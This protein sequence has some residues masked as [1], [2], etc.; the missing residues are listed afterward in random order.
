MAKRRSK[1]R[2]EPTPPA[3]PPPAPSGSPKWLLPAVAATVAVSAIA[4]YF[5]AAE[6]V[7]AP[8]TEPAQ[9]QLLIAGSPDYVDG[10]ACAGCHQEIA[11]TYAETGMGRSFYR[12]TPDT[13]A[14]LG[15][16]RS[17]THQRSGRN[18]EVREEG[19]R[20]FLRREEI[21]GGNVF[22]REIHYVMGS[23]AHARSYLHQYADGRAV[24]LPLG[25][26]SDGGGK[27]AMSPG[28]DQP[29]H[30]GFG[31]EIGFE[32]MACH[33]GYPR[34]EPGTDAAGLDPRF[35][36]R[37]VEGIDCQ[38]CHGPGKAHI[39][40]VAADQPEEVVRAA[41]FNP[42]NVGRDRQL[43][44]CMQCHLETT[45]R[46][47]PYSIVR[48]DR[49]KLSYRPSEPLADYILHFDHPEGVREDKFEIAH[50]AYRF[51]K[52]ACFEQSAEM[53]CTT[54]HDPHQAFRGAEAVERY[55]ATCKACHENAQAEHAA[56]GRVSAGGGCIECH[57]PKRRT[58]DVV[59]VVMTD[60]WIQRRPPSGDLTAPIEEVL[61][62]GDELYRGEVALYYP[63]E[64]PPD[65]GE[66]YLATAQVYEQT[67][68]EA[69]IPRL[70]ELIELERP[71]EADFYFQ[72]AEAYW[73]DDRTPE[74]LEWFEQTLERNPN[75]QIALRNFGL[76]LTRLGRAE[77][78]RSLLRRAVEAD[79]N[80]A[81][82]WTNLGDVLLGLG[83][84]A[85]ARTAL[86]QALTV[87]PDSPQALHNLA[88]V[89]AALGDVE[90]A[91]RQAR[92]AIR[93]EP[94][95][96][97]A[98]N[99][100]GKI[101]LDAGELAAAEK[102]LRR[103]LALDPAAAD[104]R[105]N[106]ASVMIA[107]ERF[108]DAESE[109]RRAVRDDPTLAPAHMNLGSVLAARN[110]VAGAEQAFRSAV[111]ADPTLADAHFNLGNALIARRRFD[112]ARTSFEE[113]VRL[114]PGYDGARLNLA[115]TLANLGDRTAAA[116]QLSR[117][118][119][120]SDPRI[121]QAAAGLRAELGL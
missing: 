119:G 23:G 78:A 121:Q 102:T 116:E 73:H 61:E 62:S 4:W 2:R 75:H 65:D 40:A 38:R 42:A 111:K 7:A 108:A 17:F 31:R 84:A 9:T 103:A 118:A 48:F 46:R 82:A 58:D 37:L 43:E 105:Y 13:M 44:V 1:K 92:E 90:G 93:V 91:K 81:K 6:K 109:L 99:T 45:S 49:G 95:F 80:D 85:A 28:F 3:P 34:I 36:G 52:S 32:C 18:Y 112:A 14:H 88:R 15:G 19:G 89:R 98:Y 39:D 51:R 20:F 77:E 67:N 107:S 22:E 66:L 87:D 96:G 117:L 110:D 72:L 71:P 83:Q 50:A 76:A 63:P 74:A 68:L 11:A 12:A 59:Q 106:L 60:H 100:L 69:G 56:A 54:C 27:L 30:G 55:S 53:T 10:A 70:R 114:D 97:P 47:L 41:I 29:V 120:S 21:G 5:S 64:P 57:M 24:E 35:P 33:N 101:E 79:P 113:A 104:A 115:V 8:P 25:W 16:D 94:S 26:Y 86:E